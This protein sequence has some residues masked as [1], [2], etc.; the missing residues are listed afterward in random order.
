MTTKTSYPLSLPKKGE[1]TCHIFP[2]SCS[3]STVNPTILLSCGVV[4]VLEFLECDKE[5][6]FLN[7][8]E[9][10]IAQACQF[11]SLSLSTVFY[12]VSDAHR[13]SC[14]RTTSLTESSSRGYDPFTQV[15]RAR[16]LTD[17]G[18][19]FLSV[20]LSL[21]LSLNFLPEFNM[22]LPLNTRKKWPSVHLLRSVR[23]WRWTEAL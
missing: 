21:S 14:A 16:L 20:S 10:V 13:A 22:P 15:R 8:F 23:L 12:N 2:D 17:V 1:T 6:F 5:E 3:V 11:F 9:F 19:P 18:E 4:F 7:S